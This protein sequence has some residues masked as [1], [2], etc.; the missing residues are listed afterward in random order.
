M[1]TN[2]KEAGIALAKPLQRLGLHNPVVLALPRGGVPVGHEVALALDAPLDVLLV[3]KIGA[4]GYEEY[5]VGAV[6]DGSDPQWIKDEEMLRQFGAP[7]GWFEA[8]VE[9]QLAEIGRR[10]RIY[11]G[12]RAPE[13][14]AGRDVVIVD[15]GLATGSTAR[16]ALLA[17][18]GAGARRLILAV[19]VA[20]AE[21]IARLRPLVDELVCLSTPEPF[22]A[23]GRHY[24]D[25]RQLE[26]QEIIDLL[27]G[28][29]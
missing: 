11:C 24:D 26:D 29:R 10:R 8:Q 7:D 27:A 22:I 6:A 9:T 18:A 14:L 5:A 16:V 25:F 21:T 15:D 17:L 3:R 19:P 2:R 12:T 20:P 28:R 1:F 23:V 4:P 13:P